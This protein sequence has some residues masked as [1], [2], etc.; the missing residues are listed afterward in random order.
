MDRLDMEILKVL[1]KNARA[2]LSDIGQKVNLSVSAVGERV[3]KLEASGVIDRYVAIINGSFFHKDLTAF[4]F[5]SLENPSYIDS[6]QAFVHGENDILECHYITGNYDYVLKVV[7]NNPATLETL[8]N[9]IKSVPGII[10][11]YTNVVL[12]TCKNNE[13]VFP[14]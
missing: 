10:K 12:A 14:E 2:S 5:I 3:K 4:M 6:F 1:Q 13:S 11:T 9:K 7:T 8:L